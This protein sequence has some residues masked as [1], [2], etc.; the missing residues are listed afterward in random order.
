MWPF[1]TLQRSAQLVTRHGRV[2]FGETVVGGT[3]EWKNGIN[4]ILVIIS[5]VCIYWEILIYLY[6]KN[7]FIECL[8]WFIYLK[9]ILVWLSFYWRVHRPG[10]DLSTLNS[11]MFLWWSHS[12]VKGTLS[13]RSRN[14]GRTWK[15]FCEH[16]IFHTVQD[17]I[18]IIY[19]I[20]QYNNTMK[21]ITNNIITQWRIQ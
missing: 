10:G 14:T 17:S 11:S 2:Q 4:G 15:K 9:C 16:K 5:I 1:L 18:K 8:N 19:P 12:K 6:F 20:T 7:V 3:K 21:K 13:Q